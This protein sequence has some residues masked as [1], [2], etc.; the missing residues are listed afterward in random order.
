[1]AV[2]LRSLLIRVV[3]TVFHPAAGL[4]H[5]PANWRETL[6]VVDFT[7]PPELLP[8]AAQVDDTLT[9]GGLLAKMKTSTGDNWW[10]KAILA[11]L[12]YPPALLWRWSLK[13][14]LWLWFPLALLLRPDKATDNVG[15]VRKDA[16]TQI[17]VSNL[18]LWVAIVVALWLGTGHFPP[19]TVQSWAGLA[20]ENAGKWLEQLLALATPPNG[21]IEAVLW[22]C[23]SLVGLVWLYSQYVQKQSPKTLAEEDAIYEMHPEPK[24]L[25]LTHS[26]WLERLYVFLVVSFILLGYAVVLH[27]ANQH[28]PAELGR[29]IPVWLL[30]WL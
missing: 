23:C 29:F 7:H 6:A 25:F 18:L 12:W 16:V 10:E 20:G 8:G 5:L 11:A 22:L 15:K 2:W 24:Q 28:Y 3:A 19:E 21:L 4:R 14:T 17:W 27:L 9:V 13:A 26:R 1:M 30:N